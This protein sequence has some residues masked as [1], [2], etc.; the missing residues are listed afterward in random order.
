MGYDS[1][2][3]AGIMAYYA[4][5]GSF[6]A[7]TAAITVSVPFTTVGQLGMLFIESAN[8][9][10]VT[11]TGWTLLDSVGIGTAGA[12]GGVR[13]AVFYKISTGTTTE[14]VSITDSGD[15]TTGIA[16]IIN[17]A[18]TT[19]PIYAYDTS[20]GTTATTTA[21]FPAIDTPPTHKLVIHALGL[22]RNVSATSNVSAWNS[23]VYSSFME[24]HDQTASSG[25]GG[26][27]AIARGGL[28]F[29]GN[30]GVSTATISS[31]VYVAYTIV[32]NSAPDTVSTNTSNFFS[33]F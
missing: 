9:N 26:G 15:H 29:G 20:T 23:S 13:L 7:S 21:T 12:A 11:P 27:I 33:F 6:E 4:T 31:Q 16:I 18:D 32:I 3:S 1:L 5:K 25:N 30:T 17:N 2:W 24:I 8:Q 19:N 22:D 14:S 10:I 28:D